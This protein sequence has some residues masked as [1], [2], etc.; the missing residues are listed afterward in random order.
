MK[1]GDSLKGFENAQ[2]RKT[3]ENSTNM[4][5][6]FDFVLKDNYKNE[7]VFRFLR[8]NEVVA[9]DG[10][11]FWASL[12]KISSALQQKGY[13]RSHI[14][15]IS[16]NCYEYL[17]LYS[18]IIYSGNVAVL[19]SKDN[20]AEQIEDESMLADVDLIFCDKAS[21]EKV[22]FVCNKLS[23]PY[24]NLIE[25]LDAFCALN[26]ENYVENTTEREDLITIFFTS[27]TTGKSKAVAM[28]N[29]SIFGMMISPTYPFTG[30]LIVLPLH[31]VAAMSM[32]ISTMGILAETH[33]CTGIENFIRDL[34]HLKSDCTF[35]VPMLLKI[36]LT[37]LKNANWDQNRLGWNLKLLA[38]G[39][40]AFPTEVVED[41]EKA[42][43][44]MPQFYGM[45]ETGGGGT[46][47]IMTMDNRF[48]IG[49]RILY[50]HEVKIVDGELV[51]RSCR[52]ML[53]YYKDPE[54]T[55]E[56]MYGGWMHTG[57]LARR[58]ENG[59]FYLTGRK[60]NLIILSNGENISP[61][62]IENKINL[63]EDV[64]ESLVYGDQKFLHVCVFPSIDE[65]VSDETIKEI[66]DRIRKYVEEYNKTAPTY[67]QLHFVEFR[68]KPFEKN[69][70]GKMVRNNTVR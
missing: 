7:I 63:S 51:I 1:G 26:S 16:A 11:T 55:N 17:L 56:I 3:I 54:A 52:Q 49:N 2:M 45:T 19:M 64:S 22:R 9:I 50:G 24:F 47:S 29:R 28:S 59:Y 42:G 53:G 31:H 65:T 67:K 35:V 40:A 46:F 30:Q 21:S 66:Q 4:K 60:K 36:M 39:G 70:L 33:I 32:Y 37:R 43:I 10:Y 68:D 5:E 14:G 61:E 12:E 18:A 13:R 41:F 6:V 15:I 38:C 44:K 34:K 27:G 58:D 23:I 57:D 69:S 48:S 20:S 62:E 8:G 25:S